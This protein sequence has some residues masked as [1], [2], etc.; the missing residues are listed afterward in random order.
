MGY[1]IHFEA[2][3]AAQQSTQTTISAWGDGMTSIQTALSALIGDSRLQGQTASS[4]KSYLSEVH[5]TLLQTLQSLMNDYSVSLLLYKDGYYQIDSNSHAQLPGQVFKTLQSELRLS[6]AHLKDQLEL[7]QNARAK[8]SDLVHYSGVSHAKTVVDYSELITDINRLDEA[9]IQ[10]E[11]NHASQDL[12]AFK[13]LL[14]STKALIAEYS[15]KPKR[16]GSYQ[17][18]DMGQLNTIKRFATAYQG[19]ARHLEINTKRLQAAQERD[20]ARFEAV[21]AA[22]RASQGWVDLALSLVTI[23]VG[24]AAIVM[25]AGAATPLVVGAFVVG[26]GTVAYGA[27]NLFEAGHNIYLGSVGDGVTVASNPLRD[28]LFMG[29][30][31]LYHQVGGLFTTASAA[32]IPIGQT[33]SVAKGLTEFTIGEVGGF[34]GGQASYHGTK[35]L[36]GSEQDAQRATLVGNILGGFAASSAARRFSLNEL[37]TSKSFIDGMNPEDSQRY[38][39]WNKYA[40]AGLSPSDRV[41]VLEISEKA[42]KIEVI[43]GFNK[44]QVFKEILSTDKDITTRPNPKEYLKSNYIEAHRHLFDN[45]AARF[46]RFQ[47]SESWN[48][49]VVGGKDGMS[50]WVS[51]DHA[52]IIEDIAKGDNHLYETLLGFDEG[53]LGNDPLYRLDLSPKMVSQKG[54]SIPSGNES[55]AN[56]WWRPG[57]RTYPGNMPECVIKGISTKKGEHTWNVVN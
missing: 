19:V 16:A 8:V 43:D 42:P 34:I 6:Q 21:A 26:S 23:A 40:K 20:Q 14:A 54:V 2:I 52:D 36:G 44:E 31:R 17:V 56:E 50:F 5:G 32:L 29:H 45:G 53:Y 35:L 39:Q 7:L 57:G 38:I 9:I 51:K 48:N 25:T 24:V 12:A 11:S 27:S 46:Q 3:S 28:T 55:G 18:G 49:G 1:K 37:P 41:R 4:I 10:Y 13:E 30:D 15:S 47:P 33:K 22:D